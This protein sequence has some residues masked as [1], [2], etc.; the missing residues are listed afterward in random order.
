MASTLS[1]SFNERK[2]LMASLGL[3][4]LHHFFFYDKSPGVSFPLFAL[5][6]YVLLYGIAGTGMKELR[7]NPAS[8]WL[9]PIALLSFTYALYTNPVFGVLNALAIPF[10]VVLHTTAAYRR[11]SR[12]GLVG[13]MIEQALVQCLLYV[14]RPIT[15]AAGWLSSLLGKG[16]SRTMGKV[17]L[18]LLIAAPL[19]AAVIGL[20]ASAD[21]MFNR[22]LS[23]LPDIW[24]GIHVL[25]AIVR[26]LWVIFVA[27]GLFA[28]IAGLLKP[29]EWPPPY[30]ER[31]AAGR[32][33]ASVRLQDTR[34]AGA[35]EGS[36]IEVGPSP[37][38]SQTEGELA[39]AAQPVWDPGLPAADV[40]PKTAPPKLDATVASTVLIALNAVY[41]LFAFVQF[42]YFFGGGAAELPDGMTYA[43]YARKGFAELVVV[44]VINLSVLVAALYGVRR[45]SPSAWSGMRALL[46]LLIVCTG[47]MLSSAY[48][49]LSMYEEAYGYTTTRL[50]VHAFM[51]FLGVL[52][53]IALVKLWNDRLPLLRSYL[54]AAVMAYV[55]MNY[56]GIDAMIV[57]NNAARYEKTGELDVAYL[58]SLGYEA[59]PHI[60]ALK[61]KH[62]DLPDE[63]LSRFRSELQRKSSPSWT[64]FN[65]SKWRAR[66]KLADNKSY[67][68]TPPGVSVSSEAGDR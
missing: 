48:L 24:D 35:V 2:L 50:L 64:E 43:A 18:G 62:P 38:G 13:T 7:A 4:L 36:P 3:G 6:F 68:L 40:R 63:A 56:I 25:E 30:A 41:L 37:G 57:R 21:A 16:S 45:P 15:V 5:A 9:L 33:V 28:Y 11:E 55:L 52:F 49:R 27:V 8:I 65:W 51:I 42:S 19:L 66:Q 44:T 32:G 29:K 60:V 53:A 10:L 39:P 22:S 23:Q 46:A 1:D 59:V 17:A 31:E 47:I 54:I 67:S 58:G 34:A 20:L 14:P 12:L 26:S 61:E